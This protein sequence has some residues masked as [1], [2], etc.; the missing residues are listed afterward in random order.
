MS[1]PLLTLQ[2][3]YNVTD[4]VR[5]HPGGADVLLDV[6]GTDATEAYEDVGHSE[7]ADEI[8]ASYLI[9]TAKDAVKHSKKKREVHV[10]QP[11]PPVHQGS[12]RSWFMAGPAVVT[13]ASLGGALL[14]YS[15][16]GNTRISQLLEKLPGHSIN[17]FAAIHTPHGHVLTGG[18]STGFLAA[19][20]ISAMVGSYVGNKLSALTHV[21]G[22][23][24]KYPSH[25]KAQSVARPNQHLVRGFLEPKTFK[26]L[27]LV[28]KDQLSPNVYRFVFQLPQSQ[29]ILGLP[30]GQHVSIKANVNGESVTRSYT[31][32]SN[33]LDLGRMELVIKCY[34][35]GLLT[36][37]YLKNLKLGDQVEFRGPRGAMKY[38]NGICKKMGMIAGGTGITP[39]FQLIRAICED[40]TDVTEVSLIYANRS[41][42]DILLR[43]ELEVFARNYPKNLKVWYM[44]NHP[45]EGWAY[46]QGHVT[47]EVIF[48]HL[49]AVTPDT[50]I[51]LCGPPGMVNASKKALVS[52][53]FQAPGAV[54]KMDDQVFCF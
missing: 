12:S 11:S 52:L 31:P 17:P 22:G 13:A 39:M 43:H 23:F 34:P 51:C 14:F 8:M 54:S 25:R 16:T 33:N 45:P 26:T 19:L 29:A 3:V 41:E 30:T 38:H 7:D 53:G 2:K 35:D 44:L 42:E 47:S 9:G 40:D 15:S 48:R 32:T 1:K 10:I 24:E 46:G 49:P 27:P 5:D 21:E 50:K 36:G 28:R 37:Q 18:F 20:L 6:A 4:Y